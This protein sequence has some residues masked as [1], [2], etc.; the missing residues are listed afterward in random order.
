MEPSDDAILRG[1]EQVARTHLGVEVELRPER[2]LTEAIE[3]DSVKKLTL[4]IEI[5]NHFRVCF[6]ETDDGAIETVGDLVAAIRR[7]S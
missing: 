4:L 5:E 2:R 1:I 3:L 7:R 6:D